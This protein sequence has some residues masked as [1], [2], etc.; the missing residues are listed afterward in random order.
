MLI[1]IAE[2]VIILMIIMNIARLI[3]HPGVKKV[4]PGPAP[5]QK[6]FDPA[7]HDVSEGEY[8]EIQ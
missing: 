8:E 7:G 4:K 6:R 3:F 5:D 1:R 2:F